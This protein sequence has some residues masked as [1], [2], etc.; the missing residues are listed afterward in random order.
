M[1]F[2]LINQA[3]PLEVFKTLLTDNAVIDVHLG[4]EMSHMGPDPEPAILLFDQTVISSV[5]GAMV[6]RTLIP[7]SWLVMFQL[8]GGAAAF[9]IAL[10]AVTDIEHFAEN[11]KSLFDHSEVTIRTERTIV[12][13]N[14][15]ATAIGKQTSA[16]TLPA[17]MLDVYAT[18]ADNLVGSWANSGEFKE[19]TKNGEGEIITYLDC[20]KDSRDK[21][22]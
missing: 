12:L 1:A 18:P 8:G 7:G 9:P 2:T 5:K 4:I 11:I 20:I 17:E 22:R 19:A 21:K 16:T 15:S 13:D 10:A 14:D 6:A 3:L